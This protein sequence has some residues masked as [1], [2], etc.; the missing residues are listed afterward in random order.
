MLAF[1]VLALVPL[2]FFRTGLVE[3]RD[4]EV[5]ATSAAAVAENLV[6]EKNLVA[7]QSLVAA[8]LAVVLVVALVV[9]LALVV[10][11]QTLVTALIRE[12][13]ALVYPYPEEA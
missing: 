11:V 13:L 12:E 7:E 9:V 5:A 1:L 2:L 3:L 8:A 6:A 10:V 4:F